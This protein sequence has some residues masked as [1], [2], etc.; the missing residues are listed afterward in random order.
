M[1]PTWLLASVFV[2][3]PP[4]KESPAP[5]AEVVAVAVVASKEE[6][7]NH[8]ETTTKNLKQIGVAVHNYV[9]EHDLEFPTGIRDEK[10]KLLLSWRVQLLPYL[11]QHAVYK[12]F[13]LD[14]AWDSETNRALMEKMPDIFQCPRVTVKPKGYTVYQGF[15]GPGSLFDPDKKRMTVQSISDG[16]TATVFAVE[17][18]TAVP[19]SK[20]ADLSFDVK[21]ELPDFGKAFA[22][23]P[24]ALMCDGSVRTLNLDVISPRTMKEA[25]T[26]AGGEILGPDW[27]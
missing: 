17:A 21:K 4:P 6:A 14:E 23:K 13:R 9:T 19:W 24:L 25:I 8:L 26:V 3:A 12:Q 27:K 1:N 10:G 15:A 20:P 7:L 11:N 2:A 22:A 5:D 18:S 16:T